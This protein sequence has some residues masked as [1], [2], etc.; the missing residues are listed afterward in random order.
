MS[1]R[2]IAS[3]LRVAVHPLRALVPAPDRLVQR[4]GDDRVRRGLDERGQAA[5]GAAALDPLRDVPGV[6]DE[7]LLEA[8]DRHLDRELAAVRAPRG[9]LH[10]A[11]QRRPVA[12][13]DELGQRA[14]VKRA[15][16]GLG[17]RVELEHA[18]GDVDRHDGIDGGFED[19]VLTRLDGPP[20]GVHAV[21]RPSGDDDQRDED[22]D[23]RDAVQRE[24]LR[25]AVPARPLALEPEIGERDRHED[26]GGSEPAHE[27]A[28][29]AG[30]ANQPGQPAVRPRTQKS[31]AQQDHRERGRQRHRRQ[32]RR[33]QPALEALNAEQVA[34]AARAARPDRSPLRRR[35]RAA[36]RRHGRSARARRRAGSGRRRC[37]RRRG[38]EPGRAWSRRPRATLRRPGCGPARTPRA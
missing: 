11:S 34:R 4:H 28:A 26:R 35:R 38:P 5:R 7:R 25:C 10:V 14:F 12:D 20:R 9:Q 6:D 18:A 31:R 19:R 33:G 36:A 13:R 21:E 8:R 37:W 22:H 15:E 32:R 29:G 17:G 30:A 3:S 23:Q 27:H 16:H 24:P 2:P 1:E